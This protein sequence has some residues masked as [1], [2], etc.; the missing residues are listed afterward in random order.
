M[1]SR[2]VYER[3]KSALREDI[4]KL[5]AGDRL[6]SESELAQRFGVTRVTIRQALSGL[7]ADGLVVRRQGRGTFVGE[8][9]MPTRRLAALT[10]FTEDVGQAGRA[11]TSILLVK[12]TVT[13]PKDVCDA[14]GLDKRASVVH[15]ARIRCVDDRRVA[16]QYAWVPVGLCPALETEPLL[17]DSLYRTLEE[18]CALR[19][20]RATRRISASSATREQ[21]RILRVP[22][23]APLLF[24]EQWTFDEAGR[25]VEFARSWARPGHS[26]TA[27]LVR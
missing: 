15:I 21:A 1:P 9:S 19:L 8:R 17:G 3:I 7:A 14:L 11:T 24:T 10:S 16:L 13:A 27:G 6:P 2:P 20:H 23:R 26:F 4:Q 12:E 5:D 25:P 18:R 22:V